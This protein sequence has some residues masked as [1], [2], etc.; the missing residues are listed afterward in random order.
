MNNQL[1][2]FQALRNDIIGNKLKN[3]TLSTQNWY[4]PSKLTDNLNKL[5]YRD[6]FQGII[7]LI[8]LQSI[9]KTF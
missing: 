4:H 8:L 6:F 2:Q 5:L 1:K 9:V 3:T 7:D